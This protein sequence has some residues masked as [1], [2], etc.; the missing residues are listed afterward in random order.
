MSYLR[1]NCI[2]HR[3][4]KPENLLMKTLE[5][6]ALIKICDFGFAKRYEAGGRMI[7]QCGTP[8]YVAP[9]VLTG[10][11]NHKCDVWSCGVLM[12]SFICGYPPFYGE[13][14]GEILRMARNMRY[15]FPYDD[16]KGITREGIDLI[17][18]ML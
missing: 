3:D 11:Y 18:T 1:S 5:K 14:D 16:W 12:Y 7:T 10:D 9:E 13:T 4:L 17:K 8:Y 6:D 2:A 15:D